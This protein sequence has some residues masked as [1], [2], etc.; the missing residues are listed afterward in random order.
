MGFLAGHVGLGLTLQFLYS[1]E[2]RVS[3]FVLEKAAVFVV[4]LEFV[5]PGPLACLPRGSQLLIQQQN[6]W[7]KGIFEQL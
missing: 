2:C 4:G 3:H 1:P 5:R 7:R 6:E